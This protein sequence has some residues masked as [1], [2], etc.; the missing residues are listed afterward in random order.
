MKYLL[1]AA[2]VCSLAVVLNAELVPC[3][4]DADG[5]PIVTD[6]PFAV[7]G[8]CTRFYHCFDGMQ[9]H[10]SCGPGHSF[11]PTTKKCALSEDVVC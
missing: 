8:D 10:A 11:D 2:L 3:G 7:E 6:G 4:N 9:Y 1:V 5:Q